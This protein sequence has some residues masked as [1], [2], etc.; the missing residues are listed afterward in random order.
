[1]HRRHRIG[2][3]AQLHGA[4]AANQLGAVPQR[5]QAIGGAGQIEEIERV[6]QRVA[7]L[8]LQTRE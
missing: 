6:G 5:A 3:A 7:V 2:L 8:L 1:M 4:G